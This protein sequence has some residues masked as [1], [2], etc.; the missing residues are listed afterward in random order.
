VEGSER[1]G[2]ALD[3]RDGLRQAA[4]QVDAAGAHADDHEVFGA[5][6]ALE[7]FVR[8]AGQDTPDLVGVENLSCSVCHRHASWSSDACSGALLAT[9]ALARSGLHWNIV[10]ASDIIHVNAP[11]IEPWKSGHRADRGGDGRDVG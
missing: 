4:G 3:V 9:P 6:V 2:L 10:A 8:H 11:P 7:D 1:D 5:V